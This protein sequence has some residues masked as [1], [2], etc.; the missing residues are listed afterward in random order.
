MPPSLCNV[1]PPV[2]GVELTHG[3]FL[4]QLEALDFLG[5]R[6]GQ[7]TVT[8]LPPWHAYGRALE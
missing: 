1:P 5:L 8:Y 3:N 2:Q 4:Y 6:P 7:T